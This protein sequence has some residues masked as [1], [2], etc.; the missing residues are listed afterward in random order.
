MT[1]QQH[2]TKRPPKGTECHRHTRTIYWKPPL[3]C[4]HSQAFIM[5]HS[6]HSGETRNARTENQKH[7]A[8]NKGVPQFLRKLARQFAC[9]SRHA[10]LLGYLSLPL[11]TE[12]A[13]VLHANRAKMRDGSESSSGLIPPKTAH[14]NI[15][16]ITAGT[17]P[18]R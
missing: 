9:I 6:R 1:M 4:L 16:V 15:H 12:L 8:F 14:K 13:R 10:Y 18:I 7:T 3:G 17:T 5:L 2:A 11:R